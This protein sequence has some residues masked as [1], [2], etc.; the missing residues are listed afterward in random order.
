MIEYYWQKKRARN[1]FKAKMIEQRNMETSQQLYV[2]SASD[3]TFYILHAKHSSKRRR[4]CIG[5]AT[6]SYT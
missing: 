3:D 5:S 1:Y 2:P 4:V 6:R